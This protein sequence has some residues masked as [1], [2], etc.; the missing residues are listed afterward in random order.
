MAGE[1]S[2]FRV[3]RVVLKDEAGRPIMVQER[4]HEAYGQWTLPGGFVKKDETPQATAI[5]EVGEETGLEIEL[6]D[7]EPILTEQLT[8]AGDECQVFLGRIVGGL[9]SPNLD[10]LLDARPLDLDQLSTIHQRGGMRDSFIMQVILS[11][12]AYA[13]FRH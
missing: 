5:R 3:A 13:H 7:D 10:E 2:R 8:D 11:Q 4:K 1:D 12:E 6:V 9:L